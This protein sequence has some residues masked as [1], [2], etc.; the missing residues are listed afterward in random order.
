MNK[1]FAKKIK[2]LRKDDTRYVFKLI[3]SISVK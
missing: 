3:Y 2:E 1:H